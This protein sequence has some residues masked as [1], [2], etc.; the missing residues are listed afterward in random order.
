MQNIGDE[1]NSVFAIFCQERDA[2]AWIR[3]QR[4]V[5]DTEELRLSEVSQ[6]KVAQAAYDRMK[7]SDMLH[8]VCCAIEASIPRLQ[9]PDT[10]ISLALMGKPRYRSH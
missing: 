5:K 1:F 8:K 7:K 10:Q 4:V 2:L 3:A 6:K 9:E